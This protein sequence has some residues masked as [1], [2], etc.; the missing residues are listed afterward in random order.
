M[1]ILFFLG[2]GCQTAKKN[3]KEERAEDIPPIQKVGG[4]EVLPE[5]VPEHLRDKFMVEEE[6]E[7]VGKKTLPKKQKKESKIRFPNRR[8][9]NDPIQVGELH[10]FDVTYFGVTAGIVDIE[11]L[12]HKTLNNRKVYHIQGRA[13]S[14]KMFSLFYR[15]NDT[16]ETYMDYLGLFSHRFHLVLDETKQSRDAIELYD[17]EKMETYY[18]NRWNHYKKG[19]VEE[20]KY[21]PIKPLTQDSLSAL[22]YVRTLDLPNGKIYKFPV[23]SEGK[24]WDLVLTVVRREWMKT[25]MGRKRTIVL[26]PETHFRGI[27]QKRGDSFI[28]LT[29]DQFRTIVRVEA[30]VKIG[31]V[32]A[33]LRKYQPGK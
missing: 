7:K 32:V 27:L 30:K 17:Y 18:W 26:K 13:R 5:D 9:E 6:K 19:F 23:V 15:L 21:E 16:V 4:E 3:E 22:Y 14:S 24:T 29:D 1:I 2:L 25:P 33:V 31:S 10:T 28:W 8:P 20:K 11:V 12:P